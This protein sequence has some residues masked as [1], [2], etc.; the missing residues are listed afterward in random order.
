LFFAQN[1]DFGRL[2]ES[3]ELLEQGLLIDLSGNFFTQVNVIWTWLD[4]HRLEECVN[5]LRAC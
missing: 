3:I 4:C 1:F 2:E 5:V